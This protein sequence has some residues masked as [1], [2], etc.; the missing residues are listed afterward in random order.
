MDTPEQLAEVR[1]AQVQA[2]ADE[3][4]RQAYYST[5]DGVPAVAAGHSN[6]PLVLPLGPVSGVHGRAS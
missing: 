5:H 4:A 3:R 6:D 2:E 1:A